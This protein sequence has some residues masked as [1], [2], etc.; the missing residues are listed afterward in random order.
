MPTPGYCPPRTCP[1]TG[2]R[3]RKRLWFWIVRW[4]W[5]VCRGFPKAG[6]RFRIRPLNW[7]LGWSIPNPGN[8]FST[9]APPPGA[10]RLTCWNTA[11]AR[12]GSWPWTPIPAGLPPWNRIWIVWVCR[13]RLLRGTPAIR[14]LGGT[15]NPSTGFWSMP[16]VLPAASSVATRTSNTYAGTKTSPPWRPGSKPS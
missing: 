15:E 5:A 1:V 16:L 10:K 6:Y 11:G 14:R 7:L 12:R 2:I 9:P 8:A 13:R 3:M 4:M